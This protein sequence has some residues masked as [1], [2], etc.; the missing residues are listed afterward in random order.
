MDRSVKYPAVK[1]PGDARDDEETV[2][3]PSLPLEAN[4]ESGTAANDKVIARLDELITLSRS[5]ND[6]LEYLVS[7]QKMP[8]WGPKKRKRP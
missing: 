4:D 5:I 1:A 6:L 3:L 7:R 8:E 2:T